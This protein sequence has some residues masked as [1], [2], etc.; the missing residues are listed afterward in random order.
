MWHDAADA[1]TLTLDGSN[2]VTEW[3]DKSASA[4]DMTPVAIGPLF[5][6]N[7]ANGKP[8]IRFN[9]AATERLQH[10]AA[11]LASRPAHIFLVGSISGVS[12]NHTFWSQGQSTSSSV[13]ATV[14]N[15][16]S[17]PVCILRG[18]GTPVQALATTTVVDNE[19]G[20]YSAKIEAA[21]YHS[22]KYNGANESA[23]ASSSIG[24]AGNYTVLGAVARSTFD[25]K[26]TGDIHEVL[27]FSRILSASEE[28]SVKTHLA[29]KWGVSL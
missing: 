2:R 28:D 15:S 24:L 23:N 3:A 9:G 16:A 11:L 10:A 1:S 22:V 4:F 6:A 27:V 8:A 18:G 19:V 25:T 13:Y 17:V 26:L 20:L 14:G 12:S 29:S 21:T 5:V 7:V